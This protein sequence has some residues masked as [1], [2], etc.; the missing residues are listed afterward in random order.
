MVAGG[1]EMRD[2]ETFLTLAEELHFGRTAERLMMSTAR[3]SQTVQAFERRI[4]GRLFHRT[5]RRVDLTPLG[6]SL[7]AELGPAF[8]TLDRTLGAARERARGVAQLLRV[9]H[10]ITAENVPEVAALIK[11]FERRAPHC[12]VV[13][14]RFD[15]VRYLDPLY[16]GDVDVWLTWWPGAFPA[17]RPA[18]GLR[19]GPPIAQ[20]GRV[21][22]VG[23]GHPLASRASIGL[24]DLTEHPVIRMS[25][26]Q[27]AVFRDSWIPRTAPNGR[28][29]ATVDQ[30]WHGHHQELATLLERD[31]Y[32]YLTYSSM[33]EALPLP[34][35][36]RAIP[37]LDA[38]PF[39]LLPLWRTSTEDATTRTFAETIVAPDTW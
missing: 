24:D 5:S 12:T 32:G 36:V 11:A 13:C 38:E 37:V 6:R 3:V 20:R 4:G 8:E 30:P 27:P 7:L 29:I 28:A 18:D 21:L 14:L 25:G 17:D 9:G 33:L 34:P 1:V 2:V 31:E 22:L 19:N 15:T 26:E 23:C 39:V 10:L 35:T 16:R